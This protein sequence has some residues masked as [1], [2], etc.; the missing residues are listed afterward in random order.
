MM[1]GCTVVRTRILALVCLS[2]LVLSGCSSTT[3]DSPAATATSAPAG[4]APTGDAPADSGTVSAAALC[5]YLRSELPKVK[6]V[7]SEVGAM[8]QLA[9]GLANFFSENGKPADGSVMDELTTK[10]CPDVRTETLKAIGK[11]SFAEL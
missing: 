4:A 11:G 8:A 10:E 5:D 2:A 7:G 1:K 6:A 9:V 3:D